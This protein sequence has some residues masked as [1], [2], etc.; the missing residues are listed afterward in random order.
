MTISKLTWVEKPVPNRYGGSD[1]NR[2]E[3]E[4]GEGKPPYVI[5]M[6]V[7]K[8]NTFFVVSRGAQH[9]TTVRSL[10]RAKAIAQAHNDKRLAAAGITNAL[11]EPAT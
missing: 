2:Y 11:A 10:D 8:G 1:T 6:R 9:Y 3:A 7:T 4:I 5:R